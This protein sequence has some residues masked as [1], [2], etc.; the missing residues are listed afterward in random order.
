MT[1]ASDV[2][3]V[4]MAAY[5]AGVSCFEFIV[6]TAEYLLGEYCFVHIFVTAANRLT[7][8]LSVDTVDLRVLP[9]HSN[10][11]TATKIAQG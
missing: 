11:G 9:R 7:L 6:V 3:I 4:V 8:I 5:L 2:R 1:Q 10:D